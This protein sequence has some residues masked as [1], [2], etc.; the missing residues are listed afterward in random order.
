MEMCT[1]ELVAMEMCTVE[2]VDM[3]LSMVASE[4][5]LVEVLEEVLMGVLE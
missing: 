5:V 4:E 1:A 2:L 3:D